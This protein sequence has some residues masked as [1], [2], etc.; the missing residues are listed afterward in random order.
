M[1]TLFESLLYYINIFLQKKGFPLFEALCKQL[2][3]DYSPKILTEFNLGLVGVSEPLT[4]QELEMLRIL[5][6]R[7]NTFLSAMKHAYVSDRT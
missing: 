7:W 2:W 4:K 3:I 5:K 6:E 1:N